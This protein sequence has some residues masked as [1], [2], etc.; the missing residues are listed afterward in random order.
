MS[1]PTS[2]DLEHFKRLVVKGVQPGASTYERRSYAIAQA[3]AKAACGLDGS[4]LCGLA[5]FAEWAATDAR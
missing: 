4:A 5:E 3:I 2:R 1:V